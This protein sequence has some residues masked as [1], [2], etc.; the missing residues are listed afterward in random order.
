LT[1]R[2]IESTLGVKSILFRP[3]YGIDHQP[4]F[5][6][7]I[8][9][10]PVAQEMGY[11]IV[12]QRIDPDDWSLR[13]GQP[14]PQRKLSTAS[15]GKRTKAILFFCMTAAAIAVRPWLRCRRSSTRCAL[16]IPASFPFQT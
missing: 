10:L 1:E 6:E 8:V 12:G 3:P 14:S 13:D 16:G 2:L 5:A 15:S 7:E 9:Q 11:L 4:E